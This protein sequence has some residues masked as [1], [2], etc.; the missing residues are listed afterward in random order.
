MTVKELEFDAQH[1]MEENAKKCGDPVLYAK[2]DLDALE[3]RMDGVGYHE[4]VTVAPG[5]Y[6][7]VVTQKLQNDRAPAWMQHAVKLGECR[8]NTGTPATY[9]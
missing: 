7:L 9:S 3:T 4:Q 6:T 1:I 5:P 8:R 2:E